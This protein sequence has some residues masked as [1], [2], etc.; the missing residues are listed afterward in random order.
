MRSAVMAA[1]RPTRGRPPPG[2]DEPPTRK[3]PGI[4]DRFAGR[5]NAARAPFEDVP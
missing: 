3:S 5:R 4:G 2:C 1:E